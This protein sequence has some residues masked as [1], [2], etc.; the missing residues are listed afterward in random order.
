M[1]FKWTEEK[2]K[3]FKDASEYTGFH[4]Q[5]GE[6]IK[7]YLDPSWTLCDLGCGLGFLDLQIADS[8]SEITAID[9]SDLAIADYK[10][11][12]ENADIHN[13]DIWLGDADKDIEG[14]WDV[15]LLSF[16]GK[17]GEE[18]KRLFPIAAKRVI[19]ITYVEP[20]SEKHG[21]LTK[22]DNRPTTKDYENFLKGEK[23][24]YKLIEKE[25][26]FGQPFKTLEDA[27]RYHES[28]SREKDP[29][30]RSELID[31]NLQNVKSTGDSE[32]PYYLPKKKDI[33]IFIV[34][35]S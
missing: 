28:Y 32:F 1:A 16:F 22:T 9:L 25:M 29:E 19:L 26:D 24:R 33:G 11:R 5:V 8:V 15:L 13:I 14:S 23:Y 17:P 2:I 35:L 10:S 34:E 4:R 18:L 12:L 30:K 6:I 20:L 7:P 3:Y 31:E 27:E 21:R